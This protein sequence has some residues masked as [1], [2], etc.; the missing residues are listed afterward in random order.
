MEE[1][2][3]KYE[4]TPLSTFDEGFVPDY[5]TSRE[6]KAAVKQRRAK[7][8]AEIVHS[9]ENEDNI[10]AVEIPVQ[11]TGTTTS[12]Y[13]PFTFDGK[14]MLGRIV[15]KTDA[16]GK[17]EVEYFQDE[18]ESKTFFVVQ[19]GLWKGWINALA[20]LVDEVKMTISPD[21]MTVKAVDPAHV[22]MITL[23]APGEMFIERK[24]PER[25]MD[26]TFK[27]EMI[28]KQVKPR[29]EDVPV[30]FSFD[31]L[32]KV[33]ERQVIKDEKTGVT[34]IYNLWNVSTVERDGFTV[35]YDDVKVSYALLDENSVTVPRVPVI[36]YE[37]QNGYAV[38]PVKQMKEVIRNAS[39]ISDSIRFELRG[40]TFRFL[41][42]S[43]ENEIDTTMSEGC[44]IKNEVPVKSAYPLDY[45]LKFLKALTHTDSVKL[46]LKDDFPLR[47]EFVMPPN[48]GGK[49]G[50]NGI[51]LL[52]PRMEQ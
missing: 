6:Q 44:E 19:Y 5:A 34:G 14:K 40:N 26:I 21:G 13:G 46:Q 33:R 4:K 2:K 25:G 32:N 24:L 18:P 31:K 22:A 37:P 39:L 29:K 43:D 35:S 45:L 28:K 51:F 15:S 3:G 38:L 50:I 16:D 41:S 9:K 12:T 23:S 8:E 17:T 42:R 30:K 52:A 11:S 48:K 20:A 36:T 49:E 47:M 10:A 1:E 27:L 7:K